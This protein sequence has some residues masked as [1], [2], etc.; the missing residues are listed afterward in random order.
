MSIPLQA[1]IAE[2]SE[3]DTL[4]LLRELKRGGYE[5]T[6][7]RVETPGELREA[8]A[9]GPWDIVLCDYTFPRF[10]GGEALKIFKETGLDLPF[11]FVSGT[12]GE[13]TAVEAMKAGAHDYVMKNRLAR[14]CP[15]VERELREAAER[16]AG[17]EAETAMRVSENK[18][19]HLFESLGDAAF[20]IEEISGRIIDTNAQA[21]TLLGRPRAEILGSNQSRL[22]APLHLKTG[23]D[24]LR[25]VANG[26]RPGGCDLEVV[27]QDGSS[28]PVHASASW[29]ILYNRRFLLALLRDVSERNRMAEQANLF[30]HAMEQ[31]PLAIALTDSDGKIVY[32]NPAFT[33]LTGYTFAEAAGKNHRILQSAESPPRTGEQLWQAISSGRSWTGE[34]QIRKKSGDLFRETVLIYPLLNDAGRIT[35]FLAVEDDISRHRGDGEP[36]PR[37]ESAPR[38]P[39]TDHSPPI[40]YRGWFE[41]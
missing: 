25:A 4:L 17:R 37:P 2:D 24:L 18:Y 23:F 38:R 3:E 39:S 20:V 21:E 9:D 5:V 32:S 6:H 13:E 31:C 11:I 14:L 34:F 33:V 26:E 35:H 30:L 16:R 28:V 1:L 10:S 29:I 12:I 15:A 19:R 41:A 36:A 8:L 40:M 27:R 22:F 7:R